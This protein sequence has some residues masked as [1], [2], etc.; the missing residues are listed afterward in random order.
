MSEVK[1]IVEVDNNIIFKVL[2]QKDSVDLNS[3]MGG[4][5]EGVGKA[6]KE[7]SDGYY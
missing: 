7:K 2:L 3:L 5:S 6:L 4:V 1:V